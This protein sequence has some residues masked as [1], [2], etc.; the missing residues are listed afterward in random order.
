MVCATMNPQNWPELSPH[1]DAALREA[2]DYILGRYDVLGLIA[3]GSII[4]GKGDATSDFDLFVIHAHPQRQRVQKRF[5][6]VP[7]EIFV[8]PPV[9]VR[10]YFEEERDRPCTANM[11]A[12]GVVLVDRD[13][14]VDVLRKEA[15]GW[16]EKAPEFSEKKLI[17]QRY[18]VVDELDNARDI[19]SS[20][21]V[22]ASRI[23]HGAVNR[24]IHYAFLASNH[25]LPREKEMLAQLVEMDGTVGQLAIDYYLA[26]EAA[27]RL[28]L[29]EQLAMRTVGAI[30]FFEWE[31][32]PEEVKE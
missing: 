21:P 23:L 15:R 1:Y 6:G 22:N 10:R 8:N 27:T 11:L 26:T 2:V 25:R 14:V 4:W 31:T 24:M 30:E 18:A 13:P 28:H 9:M 12:N 7:A 16:L 19:V 20:D 29:A 32:D 17:W 3:S 5:G